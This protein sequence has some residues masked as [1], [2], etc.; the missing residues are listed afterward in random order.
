[1]KK[2]R[3]TGDCEGMTFRGLD[4]PIDKPVEV[5]DEDSI[6]KLEGNSHFSEVK[7]RKKAED[8]GDSSA[9]KG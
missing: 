7:S 3:Y 4:F 6:K 8:N 2:F 9:D 1:M 5:E